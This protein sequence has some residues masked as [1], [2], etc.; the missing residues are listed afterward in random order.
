MKD[1]HEL[2]REINE[3]ALR[4]YGAKSEPW[5]LLLGMVE[6]IGEFVDS[7]EKNSREGMADSLGDQAI[8]ALNLAFTMGVEFP[9][10][11]EPKLI[12]YDTLMKG[13]GTASRGILKKSQG[14]RGYDEAKTRGVVSQG[15]DC[16]RRWA[17]QQVRM[18]ALQPLRLIT[19]DVWAQVSQRDWKKNPQTGAVN[20]E[21]DIQAPDQWAYKYHPVG[22]CN[23][24]PQCEDCGPPRL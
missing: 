16:W 7:R 21:Q 1:W 23:N 8:Y 4:N 5:Q 17:N 2:A 14:I 9:A 24:W 11:D 6:E 15:L 19:C 3:W 12:M 18:Y 22:R 13:I 20:D 10:F